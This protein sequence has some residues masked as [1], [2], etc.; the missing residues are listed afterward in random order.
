MDNLRASAEAFQQ[1]LFTRFSPFSIRTDPQSFELSGP[2]RQVVIDQ[3][4]AKELGLNVQ[5]LAIGVRGLIDGTVVGDFNFEGDTIDIVLIRDP[6]IPMTPED[7]AAVPLA[8]TEKDRGAA[9]LPLG[10]LVEFRRA[11]ASKSIK[12]VEQQRA[13]TFTVNPPGTMALEEARTEIEQLLEQARLAGEI[14]ADVSVKFSGNADRLSQTQ[15][16]LLGKWTG[17]NAESLMS[18][19]FSRFFLALLITF[20]LM[21]ALFESFVYPLVILFSVPMAM[22]GGF[23]GLTLVRAAHGDQ[24]LDTL[25]MLGFIILVGIVVNN[26]IL[27][28]HQ[29]LNFMRGVGESEGDVRQPLE[30]RQAIAESVRTRIRPILMTTATSVCGMLPLVVAP[31]AGSE[32]YRGLGGVVVGG[33]SISTVFTLL[34]V[35]LMLSLVIDIRTGLAQLLGRQFRERVTYVDTNM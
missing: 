5:T 34:V 4:R 22:V 2:E 13:I 8:I 26:A 14:S 35:P 18:V 30:P 24:Q 9:H 17:W 19:G 12:R 3:I 29:S 21:A 10:D 23:M 16:A 33:L 6:Q 1:R 31:G 27:L 28:V 32:I 7:L 11:D 15:Q 20:L 25:T